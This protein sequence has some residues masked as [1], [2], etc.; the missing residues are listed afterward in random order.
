MGIAACQQ[1]SGQKTSS[2][3]LI[4]SLD[5]SIGQLPMHSGAW[6]PTRAGGQQLRTARQ[7]TQQAVV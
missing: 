6:F 5:H 7:L 1:S 3:H 2:H 4:M